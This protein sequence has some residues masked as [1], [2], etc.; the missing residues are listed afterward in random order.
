MH[1]LA[2]SLKAGKVDHCVDAVGGEDLLQRGTVRHVDAVE[3]GALAGD[4]L[5]PV[6]D[7]NIAVGQIVRDDDLISGVEQLHRR[8]GADESGSAGA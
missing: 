6:D 1:R 3:R 8:V 4:R 7:G 5:D 2:H